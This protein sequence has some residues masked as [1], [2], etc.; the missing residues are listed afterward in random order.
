M[1][2]WQIRELFKEIDFFLHGSGPLFLLVA[3][4]WIANRQTFGVFG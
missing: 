2:Y 1:E 3:E 4:E